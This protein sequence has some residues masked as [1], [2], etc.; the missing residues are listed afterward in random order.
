MNLSWRAAHSHNQSIQGHPAA[1]HG[2]MSRDTHTGALRCRCQ[3]S[4]AVMLPKRVGKLAV[5]F[6][7]SIPPTLT[8]REAKLFVHYPAQKGNGSKSHIPAQFTTRQTSET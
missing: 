2:E 7:G 8:Q 5:S 4:G 3:G 1:T 6:G